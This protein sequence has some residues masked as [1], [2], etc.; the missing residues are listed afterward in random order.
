MPLDFI[1]APRRIPLFR[2]FFG[3]TI[4]FFAVFSFL[5]QP[6][7]TPAAPNGIVS[8]ELARTPEAGSAM[9]ES[10]DESARLFAAFGLGFDF[11]FMPIYATALSLAVM[12]A[13]DRHQGRNW[14]AL[15]KFFAWGAFL[16]TGF[17]AVENTA[18]FHILLNGP[19]SAASQ[20]A[21]WCASL[22]FALLLSG[23][24]YALMGWL[25]RP[26]QEFP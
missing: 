25:F 26:K 23:T 17:D 22:K 19:F 5:D 9:L 21:F 4:A 6:L 1:P 7:R 13:I 12:I 16:A 8:F 24:A 10:W 14:V 11:L 3:L 2:L 15:G 20:I 18:L